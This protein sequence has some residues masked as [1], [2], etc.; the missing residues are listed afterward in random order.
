MSL[1]AKK[2]SKKTVPPSVLLP[3]IL[4]WRVVTDLFVPSDCPVWETLWDSS[5][6]SRSEISSASNVILTLDMFECL[7]SSQT[8][9]QADLLEKVLANLS[10]APASTESDSSSVP[11]LLPEP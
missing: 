5:V 11:T 7:L 1:G 8:K 4:M 9:L 3:F 2:S 6:E 10:S